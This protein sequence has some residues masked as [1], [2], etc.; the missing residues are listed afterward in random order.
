M[1]VW[2]H[3]PRRGC[4]GRQP[5][6]GSGFAG[7]RAGTPMIAVTVDATGCGIAWQSPCRPES[8]LSRRDG[9]RSVTRL[10]VAGIRRRDIIRLGC[11]IY[12]D[13]PTES[14]SAGLSALVLAGRRRPGLSHCGWESLSRCGTQATGI[15]D[16]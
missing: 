12:Y 14:E 1:C 5:G 9:L 2:H 15:P 10:R 8:P 13:F 4:R 7:T 11:S 3:R 16:S 6:P